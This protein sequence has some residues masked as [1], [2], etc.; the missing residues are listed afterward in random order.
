MTSLTFQENCRA[1]C[2]QAIE[3]AITLD[4]AFQSTQGLFPTLAIEYFHEYAPAKTIS[5]QSAAV[6]DPNITQS[7]ERSS[8]IRSNWDFT[9]NA[10]AKIF[11]QALMK[12]RPICLLGCPSLVPP[13]TKTSARNNSVLFDLFSPEN[14]DDAISTFV[15]DINQLTGDELEGQFSSCFLDPPWYVADY[16]HWITVAS[17]FCEMGGQISFS[18]FGALTRPSAVDDRK[19]I[20]KHCEQIG[21]EVQIIPECLEYRV[22]TF[23]AA[24]LC[25]AGL[26]VVVWKK[27]DLVICTKSTKHK[28]TSKSV[29]GRTPLIRRFILDKLGIEIVIDRNDT[30]TANLIE[31]PQSGFWLDTP[32]KRSS[33]ANNSNVFTSNGAALTSYRPF[34]LAKTISNLE[35]QGSGAVKQK[36]QHLGIPDEVLDWG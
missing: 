36:L 1:I 7:V 27:S 14:T 2:S 34:D 11:D 9:D 4:H 24:M 19:T 32:S 8:F 33:L 29:V 15:F 21:L 16:L 3:N 20:L 5:L 31:P 22:P 28:S 35:G 10:I 13:I 18:L 6:S 25:R 26:P 12:E 17:R 23:E 30:T